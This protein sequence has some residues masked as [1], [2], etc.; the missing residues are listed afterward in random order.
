MTGK[1]PAQPRFREGFPCFNVFEAQRAWRSKKPICEFFLG[2][3]PIG[4]LLITDWDHEAVALTEAVSRSKFALEGDPR[5]EIFRLCRVRQ[6]FDVNRQYLVCSR[7]EKNVAQLYLATKWACGDCHSMTFRSKLLSEA[8][9]A[10][11]EL[12]ELE[13]RV[14][15]GRPK[16]MQQARFERERARLEELQTAPNPYNVPYLELDEIVEGRWASL[17]TVQ[18][19]WRSGFMVKDGKVE[20]Y[21]F[22]ADLLSPGNPEAPKRIEPAP[23]VRASPLFFPEPEL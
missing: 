20:R 2:R 11:E 22:P 18:E 19:D 4:N 3:Y 13:S 10:M 16:H 21:R 8:Q 7:C 23:V 5:F 17:D 6:G 1:D 14:G 9:R 15:K 12:D